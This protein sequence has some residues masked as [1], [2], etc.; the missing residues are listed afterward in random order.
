M[1]EK[2]GDHESPKKLQLPSSL[3]SCRLR[4]GG[5]GLGHCLPLYPFVFEEL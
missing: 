1:V 4:L 2:A 3:G 5:L